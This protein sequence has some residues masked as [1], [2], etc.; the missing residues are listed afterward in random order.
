[1]FSSG[2]G[3]FLNYGAI[4]IEIVVVINVIYTWVLLN[5]ALRKY[6]GDK[7]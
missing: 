3:G 6:L 5:R 7:E 1:M 2:I 4:A